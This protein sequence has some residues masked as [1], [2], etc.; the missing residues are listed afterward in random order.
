[1]VSGGYIR[2]YSHNLSDSEQIHNRKSPYS[3]EVDKQFFASSGREG[4]GSR[5]AF[6]ILEGGNDLPF[7]PLSL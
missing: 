4:D 3:W 2:E 7:A 6:P 1:M 5:P